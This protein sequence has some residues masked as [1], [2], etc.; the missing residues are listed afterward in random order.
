[1]RTIMHGLKVSDEY[2]LMYHQLVL[3]MYKLYISKHDYLNAESTLQRA[4]SID[5]LDD[6]FNEMLLCLYL[7]RQ[8][9]A[10]FVK[11]YNKVKSVYDTELGITLNSSMNNL[12]KRAMEQK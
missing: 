9:K 12:F 6:N 7:Q 2:A 8:E 3:E 5:P 11:Q 4:L 10:A 1:M